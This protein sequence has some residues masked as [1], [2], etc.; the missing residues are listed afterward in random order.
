MPAVAAPG[1]GS[2]MRP[3]GCSLFSNH[4]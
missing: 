4:V 2:A 3:P 1:V